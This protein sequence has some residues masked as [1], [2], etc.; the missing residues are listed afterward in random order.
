MTTK[1]VRGCKVSEKGI[2]ITSDW[3]WYN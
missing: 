3:A 2:T 1:S